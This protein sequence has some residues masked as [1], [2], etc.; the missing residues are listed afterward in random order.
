MARI[1]NEYIGYR[2]QIYM[3]EI[4]VGGEASLHVSCEITINTAQKENFDMVWLGM[5]ISIYE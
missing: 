3:M 2:F 5:P 4:V 1:L